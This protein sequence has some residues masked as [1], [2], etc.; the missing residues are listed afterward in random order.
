MS[1]GNVSVPFSSEKRK[2]EK[3]GKKS[4]YNQILIGFSAKFFSQGTA[5]FVHANVKIGR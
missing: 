4:K 1:L 3:K 5:S 2:E